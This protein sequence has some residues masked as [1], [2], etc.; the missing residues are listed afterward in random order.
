MSDLLTL[1]A[2]ANESAERRGHKL[3]WSG[4][5]HGESRSVEYAEC[6]RCEAFVSVSTRP[7]P[8]E[9]DVG[10]SAVAINCEPTTESKVAS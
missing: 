3:A 4:P 5:Y 6:E 8:N 9:I 10:G 2:Q 1:K 7:M